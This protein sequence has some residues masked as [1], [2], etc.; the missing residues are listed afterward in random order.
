[1]PIEPPEFESSDPRVQLHIDSLGRA[2]LRPIQLW[3]PDSRQEGFAELCRSQSRAL[4]HDPQDA[5]ESDWLEN[6]H[7]DEG[8]S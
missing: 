1:M 6:S 4:K 8:W 5:A 7:D 2:G 3:V